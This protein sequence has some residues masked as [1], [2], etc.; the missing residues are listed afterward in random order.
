VNEV[1]LFGSRERVAI[2]GSRDYP[3]KAAVCQFVHDLHHD[4]V[5]VSGGARGPDTWAQRTAVARGMLV[6][7]YP[8]NW[9]R[10]GK[11]AGLLRNE[12]IVAEA[13]RIVA[14]WDG[15]S[16]GTKHT[17]D[18]ANSKG[19]RVEVYCPDDCDDEE[20]P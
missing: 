15:K 7:V 10:Y 5:V 11:V 20:I 6:V 4:T 16:R 19:K 9:S 13:D 18:L 3:H 14:F 1:Y 8:A 12:L 17:I 2:V